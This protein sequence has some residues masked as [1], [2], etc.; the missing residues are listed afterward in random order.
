MG[1]GLTHPFALSAEVFPSA[2]PLR[3]LAHL[4][5]AF[6]LRSTLPDTGASPR[7]ARWTL[8]GA[9]PFASFRAGG[10]TAAKLGSLG[11]DATAAID[12]FRASAAEATSHEVA[13]ELGVP[14]SGGAVGY[15]A[16]DYG[17][18]L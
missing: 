17:R 7:R 13:G 11:S 9:E 12:A 16:Y 8:F 5:G 10:A 14:F 3:A 4:P 1:L 15:W 2:D 6:A 18:R